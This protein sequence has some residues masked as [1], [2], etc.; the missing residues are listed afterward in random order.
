LLIDRRTGAPASRGAQ[1][2]FDV[3]APA[4]AIPDVEPGEVLAFLETGAYQ[5]ASAA[6]FNGLPRPATVLV[7]GATAEVIKRGET[8]ED[9]LGRDFVPERLHAAAPARGGA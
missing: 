4:G 2:V 7:C 3:I 8:I 9:V 1:R 5:E 6:D